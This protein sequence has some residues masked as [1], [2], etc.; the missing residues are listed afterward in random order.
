MPARVFTPIGPRHDDDFCLE[1]VF[2]TRDKPR[3]TDVRVFNEHLFRHDNMRRCLHHIASVKDDVC[4]VEQPAWRYVKL[5]N[6]FIHIGDI[7][8]RGRMVKVVGR[9]FVFHEPVLAN[10]YGHIVTTPIVS[11]VFEQVHGYAILPQHRSNA[12]EENRIVRLQVCREENL[13]S[14][15]R[16][17]QCFLAS[18]SRESLL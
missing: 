8:T 17:Y 4:Q 13:I 1:R 5:L 9:I 11:R 18:K 12:P 10:L 3:S 14:F 6:G 15:A 16:Q 2:K 7:T